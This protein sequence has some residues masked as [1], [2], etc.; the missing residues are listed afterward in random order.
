MV[1]LIASIV[2]FALGI[3]F[4]PMLFSGMRVRGTTSALKAGA[5][6]G[7]LSVTLGKVLVSV[8]T[9][10]FLPIALLG[11]VGAFIIQAL[12]NA[13]ILALTARLSDGVEFD[14]LK[15]TAWAAVALTVLQT[16]V[17]FLG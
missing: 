15:T 6:G 10:I 1:Q 16:V 12:V 2:A 8:L 5:I 9:L 13:A 7:A 11:P 4:L 17:R 14:G 3:L